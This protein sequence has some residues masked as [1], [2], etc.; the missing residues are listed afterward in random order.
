L[1][2]TRPVPDLPSGIRVTDPAQALAHYLPHVAARADL[3]V[4]LTNVDYRSALALVRTEP[5]VDLLVA[6]LPGQLPAQALR[7]PETGAL[8]VTAEQPLFRHAGR[9]VGR[10]QV[11]V[12]SDGS[13]TGELWSSISLTARFSDDLEMQALLQGFME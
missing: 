9:R 4:L 11:V 8:A 2:L 6:A 5:A 7:L 12:Q 3:V 1:A 10:L 13:L